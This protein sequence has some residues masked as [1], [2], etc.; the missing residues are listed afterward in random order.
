M[1]AP[2]TLAGR[3]LAF[4]AIGA[5]GFLVQSATLWLLVAEHVPAVAAMALAVETAIVHNFVCH[6]CWTWKDRIGGM[7]Q[8]LHRF[9]V[10]NLGNGGVSLVV[11]VVLMAVLHGALGWHYMVAN[12]AGLACGSI[13]NFAL[14]EWVVFRR[15]SRRLEDSGD[16]VPLGGL[17]RHPSSGLAD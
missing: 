5:G 11:G 12:V 1:K 2:K 16:L 10:F 15:R 3:F 6:C 7:R 8:H 9:A 17:Q 14:G 4:N 13:V